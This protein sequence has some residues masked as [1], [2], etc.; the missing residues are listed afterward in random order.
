[1]ELSVVDLQMRE[2]CAYEDKIDTQEVSSV[3]YSLSYGNSM[4]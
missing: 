4:F 3:L 1:M 2:K